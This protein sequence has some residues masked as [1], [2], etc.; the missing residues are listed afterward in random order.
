MQSE[1]FIRTR[2]LRSLEKFALS[3]IKALKRSDFD[4]ERFGVLVDKNYGILAKTEAAILHDSYPKALE[5][6][7][8]MCVDLKEQ[9]GAQS[10]L[11]RAYN[12][13]EKFKKA[14]EYKREKSKDYD[15]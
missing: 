10:T 11:L 7:V 6:F 12:A 14:K 3:A 9:D 1:K 8:Q 4:K 2:Y 13:L 5:K 15:D